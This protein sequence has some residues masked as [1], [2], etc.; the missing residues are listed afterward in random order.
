MNKLQIFKVL[1]IDVSKTDHRCSWIL[2]VHFRKRSKLGGH[3]T[4]SNWSNQQ[5]CSPSGSGESVPAILSK[6]PYLKKIETDPISPGKLVVQLPNSSI[7]SDEWS[8]CPSSWWDDPMIPGRPD[9]HSSWTCNWL[10][11]LLSRDRVQSVIFTT[12]QSGAAVQALVGSLHTHW[13][14]PSLLFFFRFCFFWWSSHPSLF[15]SFFQV[16][17]YFSC[18][19]SS[20][21]ANQLVTPWNK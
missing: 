19:L 11:Q 20:S 7:H 16:E 6:C 3:L 17:A 2:R 1:N 8:A 9:T 4:K 14:T 10:H 13:H 12:K 18:M 15:A 21:S 5:C